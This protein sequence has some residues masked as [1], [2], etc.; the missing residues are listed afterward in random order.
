MLSS[1]SIPA[2]H[3]SSSFPRPNCTGVQHS[4]IS[5]EWEPGVGH[6]QPGNSPQNLSVTT[7]NQESLPGCTDPAE[8]SNAVMSSAPSQ[9][10]FCELAVV[11]AIFSSCPTSFSTFYWFKIPVFCSNN[12]KVVGAN[13]SVFT[14]VSWLREELKKMLLFVMQ[15]SWL[16]ERHLAQYVR[17]QHILF[18]CHTVDIAYPFLITFAV[19]HSS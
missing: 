13:L 4:L 5:T 16:A 7:D 10:L 14:T 17:K 15:V 9:T 12:Y 1:S 6:P 8:A 18:A 2:Q 11:C 3:W 19:Y